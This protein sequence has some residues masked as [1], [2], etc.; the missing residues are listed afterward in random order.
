MV[1][2]LGTALS[3]VCHVD[4]LIFSIY[5]IHFNIIFIYAQVCQAISFFQI[6]LR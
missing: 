2:S 3:H 4:I 1:P 5:A 6:L